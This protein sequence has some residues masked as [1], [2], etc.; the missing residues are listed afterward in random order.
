[1]GD[2]ELVGHQVQP[3]DARSASCGQGF[4]KPLALAHHLETALGPLN[5]PGFFPFDFVSVRWSGGR[6][7]DGI[8]VRPYTFFWL[9]AR[10]LEH[11]GFLWGR[12][13]GRHLCLHVLVGL[14]KGEHVRL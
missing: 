5:G 4:P 2:L 11:Q 6:R 3:R 13:L 9:V 10:G 7:G 1:V 12:L 8:G 14:N